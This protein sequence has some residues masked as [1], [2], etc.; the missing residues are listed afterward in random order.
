MRVEGPADDLVD[1]ATGRST[2]SQLRGDPDAIAFLANLADV[3]S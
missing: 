3:M 1:F 2:G